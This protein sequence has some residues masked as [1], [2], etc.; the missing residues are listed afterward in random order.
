MYFACMVGKWYVVMLLLGVIFSSCG[1][2]GTVITSG[3]TTVNLSRKGLTEIPEEVFL[4]PTI[5]VLKLYGNHID[6]LPERIGELVN[7]EKL[8][9][10][11]NQLKYIPESIGNLKQLKLFSA[12]YNDLASLPDAIGELENLEQLILNQNELKSLPPTIGNLKKL[13]VLQLKFNNLKSLPPELG[14][15]EELQF[16]KLNRNFLETLPEELGQLQKLRELYLSGAG[17]L[18]QL[19]ESLC[20]IRSLE[21]LEIDATTALPPCLYVRQTSRLQIIRTQ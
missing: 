11:R 7:L 13:V 6:S 2:R 15:C 19:P 8:Y 21:V 9:V 4:N 12:Q 17:P 10:G 14:R 18:L 3:Q 16:I 1:L 5:R 20:D